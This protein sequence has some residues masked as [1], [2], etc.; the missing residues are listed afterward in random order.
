[1]PS[2]RRI[3]QS[4]QFA[5][6]HSQGAGFT[7]IEVIVAMTILAISLVAVLQLF[8]GGLKASSI[9]RNY[10]L[11]IAH[12][13][14]KMEEL[15]FAPVQ[16]SGEFEDGF[17]WE[18]DVQPYEGLYEELNARLESSELKLLKIIVK[19]SWNSSRNKQKSVQLVTLRIQTERQTE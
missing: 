8:S 13:K 7:L 16:D 4:G 1:M 6:A 5:I 18:S 9:S 3:R 15:S 12:A 2:L 14:N 11:A 10:T 17:K 19:I